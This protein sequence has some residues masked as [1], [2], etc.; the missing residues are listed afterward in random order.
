MVRRVAPFARVPRF[1]DPMR[2]R[3]VPGLLVT[4]PENESSLTP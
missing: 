2:D 1:T 3:D 4:T